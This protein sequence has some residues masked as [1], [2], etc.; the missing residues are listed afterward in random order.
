V[1]DA[2]AVAPTG[3]T[4]SEL[5]AR[6]QAPKTSLVGLL[7]G[8]LA[9]GSIGRD[10]ARRYTLG[11]RMRAFAVQVLAGRELVVLVRPILADLAKRSGE[12]AL[13]GALAPEAALA[14]YLDKVESANPIR[15][16]VSVGERRELYCTAIGKVLLASWAPARLERYLKST[17]R[18]HWTPATLV[19]AAE[20]KRALARVGIDG[21]AR[22]FDERFAGASGI[23]APVR[24]PKGEVVAAIA[25]VGPTARMRANAKANEALLRR[26]ATEASRLAGGADAGTRA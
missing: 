3:A 5:A 23:A 13:L 21:I 24:G 2:L 19:G 8:M 11:P 9:E 7:S 14:V 17:A 12:T 15:Y 26:A 25:V 1:L 18:T 10:G 16:A 6:L 4:L 20:L 22:T